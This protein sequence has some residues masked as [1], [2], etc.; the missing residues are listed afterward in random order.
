MNNYRLI[1]D[2]HTHTVYSHGKSSPRDIVKSAVDAGLMTIAISEHAGGNL[3][4]GLSDDDFLKLYNEIEELREIYKI[5]ILM[6]VELN[7]L[8]KG[9]TDIP[10]LKDKLDVRIMGYHKG[11]LVK[12]RFT[13]SALFESFFHVKNTALNTKEYCN[14]IMK[15]KIDIISHPSLYISVDIEKLALFCAENNILLEI[16][17]HHPCDPDMLK[18][19]AMAG[20]NFIIGSDAHIASDVGRFDSALNAVLK[21]GVEDRIVNL[22]IEG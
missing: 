6:G 20:A 3:F 5:N 9:K 11:V 2:L 7:M 14:V 8:G 10:K 13:L 21:A 22:R 15:N 12:N 1:A 16:N 4:Y 19:A 17:N 18:K